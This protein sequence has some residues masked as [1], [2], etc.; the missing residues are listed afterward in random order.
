MQS[1]IWRSNI[2][3]YRPTRA[4]EPRRLGLRN[5]GHTSRQLEHRMHG[6]S[7]RASAPERQIQVA[8]AVKIACGERARRRLTE[9]GSAERPPAIDRL[10]EG[11]CLVEQVANPPNLPASIVPLVEYG[12]SPGTGATAVFL[13]KERMMATWFAGAA[14]PEQAFIDF[15]EVLNLNYFLHD[16][17]RAEV[18]GVPDLT[19]NALIDAASLYHGIDETLLL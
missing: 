3:S 6:N 11:L 18:Y 13:Q 17:V 1:R 8:V 12:Y 7:G 2:S 14:D 10:P 5:T 9:D 15:M 16:K 4:N 19:A